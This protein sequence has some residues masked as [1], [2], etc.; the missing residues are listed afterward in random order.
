MK[1]RTR[2]NEAFRRGQLKPTQENKDLNLGK[3]KILELGQLK[4]RTQP[5]KVQILA[6]EA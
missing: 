4:P 6:T 1:P 3:N 2:T 5:N